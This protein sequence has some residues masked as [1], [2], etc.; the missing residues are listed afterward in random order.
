MNKDSKTF[1]DFLGTEEIHLSIPFTYTL[2]EEMPVS[3]NIARETTVIS[4]VLL[5]IERGSIDQN[6]TVELL[7]YKSDWNLLIEVIDKIES[8]EDYRFDFEI[9]Q[10]VVIITDTKKG[11]EI[12]EYSG[13]YKLE[14]TYSA[15]LRFIELY[16][17]GK[18]TI[19]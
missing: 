5:E 3:G 1:R 18:Y 9:R 13:D 14:V 11:K 2:G 12:L 6:A 7:D 16:N 8:I 10:S 19:K 4:E 17:L 15:C